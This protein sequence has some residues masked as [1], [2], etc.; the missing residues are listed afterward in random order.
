MTGHHLAQIN[1]G[2]LIGPLDDPRLAGFVALLEPVNALA[3]SSD[4]FVWRYRSEGLP[5]ATTERPFGPDLLLNFSV[6]ES[7]DALWEFTYRSGHLDV[8]R[9]RRDWFANLTEAYAAL[10]WI[11]AGHIPTVAEAGER[12]RLLRENGPTPAAFT[13][14]DRFPAPGP[15]E[16][17]LSS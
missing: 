9:R 1:I 14:R 12:L 4:G 11:P 15:T 5:D 17:T 10:W 8:L 6:W 16:A 7:P 3:D 13:F 2:R